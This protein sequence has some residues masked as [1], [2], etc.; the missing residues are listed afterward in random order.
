MI[1]V[2]EI[3]SRRPMP[4]LGFCHNLTGVNFDLS[5][6]TFK[7]NA[8]HDNRSQKQIMGVITTLEE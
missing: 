3:L 5:I 2:G 1:V 7:T 4:T 6:T 8:P